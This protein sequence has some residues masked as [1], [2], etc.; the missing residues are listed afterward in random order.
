MMI[1]MRGG[2]A[3]AAFCL[4]LP[5][6]AQVFTS[7]WLG[8][9]GFLW[10]TCG[11][12]QGDSGCFGGG[13]VNGYGNLCAVMEDS[14]HPNNASVSS[15][16][17]IYLLDNNA[18]GKDDVVLHVLEKKI[19]VNGSS[20]QTT[21]TD[22]TDVPLSIA[23]GQPCQAAAN[24]NIIAAGIAS[25]NPQVA[26]IDKNTLSVLPRHFVGRPR[27]PGRHPTTP[28][29]LSIQSDASGYISIVMNDTFEILD[30]KGQGEE[31]GGGAFD[32]IPQGNALILP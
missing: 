27:P 18:T 20:A 32:V 30:P 24:K 10:E 25:Q 8:P 9:T 3:I 15:K 5:A 29:M 13:T 2:V 7:Y 11:S 4:A 31:E 14:E 28:G 21:F 23:G 6:H 17:R 19:V 16:Q 12:L 22:V 1:G 26:L